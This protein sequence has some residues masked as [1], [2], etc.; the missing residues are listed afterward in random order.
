MNGLVWYLL[1]LLTIG[2]V[3]NIFAWGGYRKRTKRIQ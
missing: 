2:I 1:G 3:V